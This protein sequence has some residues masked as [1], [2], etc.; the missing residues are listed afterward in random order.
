[1]RIPAHKP[2]IGERE[3]E[4]VVAALRSGEIGGN[5]PIGR[6]VEQWLQAKFGASHALLT[7]SCTH[8]MEL[9][10][11][12]LGVGPGDEVIL[13]SFTFTSTANAVC[14]QRATPVFAEVEED[15]LTIDPEDVARCLTPRSKVIMPVH[16]AGVSC[17]MDE[18][19]AIAEERG[20]Y[21]VEDAA[22]GVGARYKGVYLGTIGH[23]GCYSFHVTKNVTCGEGGALLVK[24]PE[25]FRAA[26]MMREKGTN[27]SAFLR[28]EVDKYTWTER[29]SSYV[30]SDLLAAV[31]PAQLSRLDEI[32]AARREIYEC[33][34]DG[35]R[36]LENAEL[37]RLPRIPAYAESNY[38]IFHFH[39]PS[40]EK[41]DFVLGCLRER[42]I[43][44]SFHY[45]PLHSSPYGRRFGV[46]AR[47]LPRTERLSSTLVRLPIYPELSE[48]ERTYVLE[49]VRDAVHRAGRPA[50]MAADRAGA[51]SGVRA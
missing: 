10:L 37:I 35:L 46:G 27:R 5:G 7:P 18:L 40:Q 33:Y 21:V 34:R 48:E 51:G 15:T 30:L 8:A 41:R 6:G 25:R 9:A 31:L 24:D 26:E 28:G 1:M 4:A 29:G 13:P 32:N 14:L 12:V 22:Q 36:D 19:L 42:G 50:G 2:T 17:R 45:V 39:L 49:S 44:A 20:L 3:I 16:Y 11:M 38:H 23:M 43:G 47:D